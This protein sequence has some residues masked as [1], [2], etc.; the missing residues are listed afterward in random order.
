MALVQFQIGK[1][2]LTD[3]FI[4]SLET[5]FKTNNRVKVYVLK[6]GRP[7]GKEGKTQVEKYSKEILEKLG[8]IYTAKTIGFTINFKKWRKPPIRK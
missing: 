5:C 3:G 8:K 1:Q 4:K 6:S 2:G 7:D